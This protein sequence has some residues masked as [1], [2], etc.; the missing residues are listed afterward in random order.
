MTRSSSKEN[1][2]AIA[3]ESRSP[4]RAAHYEP[5]GEP[6]GSTAVPDGSKAGEA[7]KLAD[8]SQAPANRIRV[9]LT[10]D[11]ALEEPGFPDWLH[12]IVPEGINGLID[13]G[14]AKPC[15]YIGRRCQF[16]RLAEPAP[17]KTKRARKESP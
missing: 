17:K 9:T 5:A 13:A 4:C 1:C 16:T 11:L 2:S 10:F 12:E 15:G 7:Q 8:V 3:A 14:V 6:S